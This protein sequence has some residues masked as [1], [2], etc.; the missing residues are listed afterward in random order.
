VEGLQKKKV[1]LCFRVYSYLQD[2][3]V[4]DLDDQIVQTDQY[5]NDPPTTKDE[6]TTRMVRNKT[7]TGFKERMDQASLRHSALPSSSPSSLNSS[8]EE[9]ISPT[10]TTRE[11]EEEEPEGTFKAIK[12]NK[13]S[14]RRRISNVVKEK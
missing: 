6:K 1:K 8:K 9:N 11:P 14:N 10:T 13:Q 5:N 3:I 12:M 7:S 4:T 2:V